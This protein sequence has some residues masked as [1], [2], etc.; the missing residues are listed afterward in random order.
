[1]SSLGNIIRKE[2][3]E[4]LTPSALIP[5]IILPGVDGSIFLSRRNLKNQTTSGVRKTMKSGFTVWNSSAGTLRPMKGAVQSLAQKVRV[6]P[7]CM[8]DIQKRITMA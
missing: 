6:K 4:L 5:I 2:V 7:F 8:K 1:M 3:K